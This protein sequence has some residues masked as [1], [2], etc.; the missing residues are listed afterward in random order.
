VTPL[1]RLLRRYVDLS[2][3]TRHEI[4]AAAGIVTAGQLRSGG[5]GYE[6]GRLTAYLGGEMPSACRLIT[7]ATIL[8]IPDAELCDALRATVAPKE[9]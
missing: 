6:A 5:S 4:A 7:L 2:P 9:G 3:L 1:S 8:K